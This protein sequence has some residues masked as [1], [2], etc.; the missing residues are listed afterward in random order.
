MR[1]ELLRGAF[2]KEEKPQMNLERWLG[3]GG[4]ESLNKNLHEQRHEGA[5]TRVFL[6]G[7]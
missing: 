1:R 5:P 2:T 4:A 6:R 3:F 7:K